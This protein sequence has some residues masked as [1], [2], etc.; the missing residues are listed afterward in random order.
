MLL[1][2]VVAGVISY[3]LGSIPFGLILLRV[4]RGI[5]V[6]KTGSGNIGSANVARVAPG[7]GIMTLVLDCGKGLL[8][9]VI[10]KQIAHLTS[11]VPNDQR[12]L[13][14]MTGL[15]A[16]LSICGHIFSIWLSFKGG[17]GVATA[18]GAYLGVSPWVVLICLLVW[19]AIYAVWHYTSAGSIAFAALFPLVAAFRMSSTQRML[20]LPFIVAASLLIIVKHHENIRRLLSGTENR[21]ELKRR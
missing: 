9:V 7:L 8:A 20:L 14:L 19:L 1:G 13:A 17:K 16:L 11:P 3:L 21:L 18:I 5:D 10:A 12:Y 15:A 2:C 4:F 6:R